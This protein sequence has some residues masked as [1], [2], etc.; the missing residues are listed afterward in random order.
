MESQPHLQN[1]ITNKRD[2]RTGKTKHTKRSQREMA[3]TEIENVNN[4]K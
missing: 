2:S 3:T 1:Q 4:K